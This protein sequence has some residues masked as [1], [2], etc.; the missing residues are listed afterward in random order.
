LFP[1]VA[2]QSIDAGVRERIAVVARASEPFEYVFSRTAWFGDDEVL[3]FA[4]EEP[5]PFRTLTERLW[6]TFPTY[7]PYGRQFVDVVPHLT[8]GEGAG[9]DVDDGRI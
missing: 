7:P 4:P 5:G 8:I 2:P 3:C 6:K 1:F 9:R